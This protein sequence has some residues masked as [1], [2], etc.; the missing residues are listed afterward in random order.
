MARRSLRDGLIIGAVA[1]FSA[2]YWLNA[3]LPS[4]DFA[5]F[6]VW[7]WYLK[8][9][10]AQ[11][12]SVPDYSQWWLGGATFYDLFPFLGLWI[13]LP[14]VA[15]GS[16]LGTK[17]IAMSLV[18]LSGISMYM[19]AYHLSRSR[20]GALLAGVAYVTFPY[21]VLV[22][23]VY[24]HLDQLM[25]FVWVPVVVLLVLKAIEGARRLHIVLAGTALGVLPLMNVEYVVTLVPLAVILGLFLIMW[26]WLENRGLPEQHRS[27]LLRGVRRNAAVLAL[28]GGIALATSA[29]WSFPALAYKGTHILLLG[30]YA[31]PFVLTQPTMLLDRGGGDWASLMPDWVI[32][33][34]TGGVHPV[35]AMYNGAFYLGIVLL[36]MWLVALVNIFS[37]RRIG[38]RSRYYFVLFSVVFVV[39]TYLA[40]GTNWRP[41]ARVYPLAENIRSPLRFLFLS[42]LA[43]PVLAAFFC[44][45][46]ETKIASRPSL[47]RYASAVLGAILVLAVLLDFYPYQDFYRYHYRDDFVAD[48]ER[49]YV[50]AGRDGGD[51]RIASP[52]DYDP[53]YNM[54]VIYSG[55]PLLGAWV[56]W[57]SNV[58]FGDL[59]V[60]HLLPGMTVMANPEQLAASLGQA[61]VKYLVLDSPPPAS[62]SDAF[63]QAFSTGRFTVWENPRWRPFV[64]TSPSSSPTWTRPASGEIAISVRTTAGSLLTVRESHSLFWKAYVDG[65]PVST[66]IVDDAFLGIAVPPGEHQV[67]L[68]FEQGG[69]VFVGITV[70]ALLGATLLGLLVVGQVRRRPAKDRRGPTGPGVA[71]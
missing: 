38:S 23:A 65:Q 25:A 71:I 49:A 36:G 41:L 5:G 42:S 16:I 15:A 30:D 1:V 21:H 4:G 34:E 20:S 24:F 61:N 56:W 48:L 13:I 51:Y 70:T 64:E 62:L 66:A 14:A 2:R 32:S 39:G 55:K 3:Y 47:P 6:Y 60:R 44:Q 52:M 69:A 35:V 33:R 63:N 17:L 26:P 45:W 31:K 37:D 9:S 50:F 29:W 43:L 59:Y 27:T 58:G 8:T 22:T 19:L 57:T 54:G 12:H 10:L 18:V 40:L 7:S 67:L 28:I 11:Y 68:R 53:V 46:A